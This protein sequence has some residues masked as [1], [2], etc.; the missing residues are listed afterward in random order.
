MFVDLVQ[1]KTILLYDIFITCGRTV[2]AIGL[3]NIIVQNLVQSLGPV[4][5]N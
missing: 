4:V 5:K 2:L 1:L 3:S